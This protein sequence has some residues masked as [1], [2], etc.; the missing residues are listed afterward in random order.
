MGGDVGYF[1]AFSADPTR[2]D[3]MLACMFGTSGDGMHDRLIDYTRPV[4]GALYFAPSSDAL[5]DVLKVET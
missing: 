3:R 2:Y 4:S 1:V 5:K